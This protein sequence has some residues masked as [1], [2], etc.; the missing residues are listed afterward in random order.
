MLAALWPGWAQVYPNLL[1]SLI[2]AVPGTLAH[3]HTRRRLA[4][5]HAKIDRQEQQP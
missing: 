5:L 3:L 2:W 4:A 1:A